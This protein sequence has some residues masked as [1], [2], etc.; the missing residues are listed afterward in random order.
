MKHKIVESIM[1]AIRKLRCVSGA[2]VAVIGLTA[3]LSAS[4]GAAAVSLTEQ[5]VVISAPRSVQPDAEVSIAAECPTPDVV[6][7]E[8]E[9][10]I[11]ATECAH[12]AERMATLWRRVELSAGR[13]KFPTDTGQVDYRETVDWV[14]HPDWPKY[15]LL[16]TAA[17]IA[18]GG[19]VRFPDGRIF[20]FQPPAGQTPGGQP[21]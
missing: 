14:F 1:S 4:V 7:S 21:K 11:L 19:V 15:M 6:S 17:S 12:A 8:R 16:P 3:L 13:Q 2:H 10:V 9:A 20:P 18:A 5:P